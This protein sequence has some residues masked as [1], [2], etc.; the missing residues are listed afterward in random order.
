MQSN[1]AQLV[2]RLV[3]GKMS[4]PQFMDTEAQIIKKRDEAV[5]KLNQYVNTL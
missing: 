4:K 1:H 3:S 2:E 5:E